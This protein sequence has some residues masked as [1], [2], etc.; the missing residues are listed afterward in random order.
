M[1]LTLVAALQAVDG[2]ALKVLVDRWAEAPAESQALLFEGAYAVRQ[3]E[4]SLLALFVFGLGL[5]VLVYGVALVIDEEAPNWLGM[6]GIAAGPLTVILAVPLAFDPFGEATG[7]AGGIGLLFGIGFLGNLLGF[8][9]IVLVGRFLLQ[10]A[11]RQPTHHPR[12]KTH[13]IEE[14]GTQSGEAH[15]SV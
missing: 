4:G 12:S 15:D 7:H 2:I 10:S 6:L 8:L 11:R 9:W 14:D 5:T 13:S 1:S 3:I